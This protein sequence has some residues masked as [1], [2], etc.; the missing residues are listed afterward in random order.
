[1]TYNYINYNTST[2]NQETKG[3]MMTEICIRLLVFL[4]LIILII[5]SRLLVI[6][7]KKVIENKTYLTAGIGLTTYGIL[8]YIT[9]EASITNI[10][11]TILST[12]VVYQLIRVISILPK[13]F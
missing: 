13:G 1:M 7:G 4:E 5:S 9:T 12:I 3:E 10:L 6:E 8:S 2:S 11:I